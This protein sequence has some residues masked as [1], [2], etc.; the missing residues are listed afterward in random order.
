MLA[1]VASYL[2]AA[3]D[4]GLDDASSLQVPEADGAVC[5]LAASGDERVAAGMEPGKLELI[6]LVP[7]PVN[8]LA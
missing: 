4:E 7:E 1:R 6:A 5:N 2:F 8:D 3:F